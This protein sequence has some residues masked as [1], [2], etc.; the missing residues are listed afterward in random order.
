[1][2]TQFRFTQYLT[3]MIFGCIMY[4]AKI[5]KDRTTQIISYIGWVFSIS[6]FYYHLYDGIVPQASGKMFQGYDLTYRW[7]WSLAICWV[8]F[9]C[10]QHETG[11]I[12]RKFLSLELWQPLSKIGL[13][14]YV[15]HLLYFLATNGFLEQKGGFGMWWTFMIHVGDIVVACILGTLLYCMCEAPTG[16]M[17]SIIWSK[18]WREE[19][20]ISSEYENLITFN[21]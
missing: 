15:A 10:H 5:V 11:G 8:V 1:M 14:I 13:S 6:V 9:A 20:P 17:L 21:K 12:I 3:G 7:L 19:K 4:N 16:R 18:K 2:K